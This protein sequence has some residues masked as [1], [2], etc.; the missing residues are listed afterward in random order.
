MHLAQQITTQMDYSSAL[1]N[2]ACAGAR[3]DMVNKEQNG[4]NAG[5]QW[6]QV[7]DR[8]SKKRS[9]ISTGG[10]SSA[11][12]SDTLPIPAEYGSLSTDEKLNLILATMSKINNL[13]TKIDQALSVTS[14]LRETQQTV[15]KHADRITILEYKSI[16]NEA[17]ARRSNLLFKGFSESRNENCAKT[18]QD[19]LLN[20][21]GIEERIPTDRAHRLGR[22]RSGNNRFII[23]AFTYFNDTEYI[24]SK[25]HMLK[26][27]PYSIS[28]DFPHEIVNARKILWPQYKELRSRYNGAQGQSV[29]IVYPAKLVHNGKVINDMFPQWDEY[30]RRSRVNYKQ[31]IEQSQTQSRSRTNVPKPSR[32][33]GE[34]SRQLDFMPV[35]TRATDKISVTS[36]DSSEDVLIPMD[37]ADIQACIIPFVA[38]PQVTVQRSTSSNCEHTTV[39]PCSKAVQNEPASPSSPSLLS[40]PVPPCNKLTAKDASIHIPSLINPVAVDIVSHT[41]VTVGDPASQPLINR[42]TNHSELTTTTSTPSGQVSKATYDNPSGSSVTQESVEHSTD[43]PTIRVGH[44]PVIENNTQ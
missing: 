20:E 26:N 22:F 12:V 38:S 23:V 19:F 7:C 42:S 3:A 21:L 37:T 16:D 43:P 27:K 17:R 13:E 25:G 35:F 15:L 11:Y 30:M 39:Q 2:G 4:G 6:T 32:A 28:R 9:R 24:L 31:L 36:S 44:E 34:T 10:T 8:R 29:N 1:I 40:G 18:V 14:T 33:G 5:E 41:A